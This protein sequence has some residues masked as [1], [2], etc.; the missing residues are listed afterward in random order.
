MGG[1]QGFG[2]E[3]T[4]E[5]SGGYLRV[6]DLP[7]AAWSRPFIEACARRGSGPGIIK[8]TEKTHGFSRGM[9][10]Q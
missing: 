4:D 1:M 8:Q 6:L 2:V 3:S 7:L 5:V 9:N 10:R